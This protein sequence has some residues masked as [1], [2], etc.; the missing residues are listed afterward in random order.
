MTASP[1]HRR[2]SLR[3]AGAVRRRP[4]PQGQPGL[5]VRRPAPARG[6]RRRRRRRPRR[7]RQQHRRRGAAPARRPRPATTCSARSPARSTARTTGSPSSSSED[8]E[9]DGTSTTVTAALFDGTRIGVGHVGD[10]R[11]YLL[12]DGTLAQL[13]N[14]HTFVQSLIDEGRITEEEARVHPHRNLILRR[15]TACTSPSPTCSRR[16][17]ARGPAPAV[18]RRLLR[19]ARR[20]PARRHPR[21]RLRRLRRRRADPRLARRRQLRQRHLRR[22]RRVDADDAAPTAPLE[23]MLVGAAAE[24]PRRAGAARRESFFRGHRSGDTGELEPVRPR[25]DGR[26]RRTTRRPRGDPLRAAAAAPVHLGAPAGA[27]ARSS[28]PGLGGRRALATGGARASTTSPS[29]TADVGDLPRRRGRRA[30]HRRL[31]AP[32]TSTSVDRPSCRPHAS[33][34]TRWPGRATASTARASLDADADAVPSTNLAADTEPSAARQRPPS[35]AD[36]ATSA[37]QSVGPARPRS[38]HACARLRRTA[39]AAGPSC[40]CWCSAWSS[41]S[42]RTPRSGSASTARSRPTSSPTAAGWPR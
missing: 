20:R 21:Q 7:H 25:S 8:P 4:G 28:S 3:Y 31:H 41:A 14:D 35:G 22:R 34:T 18:Q 15:S 19:R 27:A 13:T 5:R 26:S 36:V 42:A 39:A 1:T 10:S 40:S 23:P 16:A 37:A 2:L 11:G 12:R 29:T 33:A 9:L 24:Q 6:R 32:P 38:D 17:R 30:R